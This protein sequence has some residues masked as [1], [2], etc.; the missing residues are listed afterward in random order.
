MRIG[1]LNRFA[2]L[3]HQARGRWR[4]CCLAAVMEYAVGS[5]ACR[6]E[7]GKRK[8]ILQDLMKAI[9]NDEELNRCSGCAN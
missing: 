4:A 5:G 7:L 6:L 2:S 8:R 1:K 3:T 9:R